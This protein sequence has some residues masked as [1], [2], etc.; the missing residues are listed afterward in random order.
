MTGKQ[1]RIEEVLHKVR[2]VLESTNHLQSFDIH[3]TGGVGEC[4]QIV[5]YITEFVPEGRKTDGEDS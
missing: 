3:V 4:T 5:Y 1:Q 2:A